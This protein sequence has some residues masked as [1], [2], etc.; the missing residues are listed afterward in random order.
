M[1]NITLIVFPIYGIISIN[2]WITKQD[3]S[4]LIS[5]PKTC[6]LLFKFTTRKSGKYANFK[7]T[8]GNKKYKLEENSINNI[9]LGNYYSI[10]YNPNNPEDAIVDWSEQRI[11]PN[12]DNITIFAR[13]IDIDTN[14][15]ILDWYKVKYI[16]EIGGLKFEGLR[17]IKSKYYKIINRDSM[18]CCLNPN[19][20]ACSYL[21]WPGE[22]PTFCD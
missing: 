12:Y 16:Y 17:I 6:G 1:L 9:V 20:P 8:V 3:K 18:H 2:K 19:L 13:I 15:N 14:Q 10:A 11:K 4:K 5:Y 21:F 7:Y 22:E